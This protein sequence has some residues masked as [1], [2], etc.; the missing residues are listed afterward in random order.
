MK[1]IAAL[2]LAFISFGFIYALPVGNPTEASLFLNG[3]WCESTACDPCDPCFSWCDAWSFRIGFYG[4]YVF[5]R[6]LEVKHHNE[7]NDAGDDIQTTTLFTNAGYLVLNFCDRLDIFATLG[8]TH[9]H[10]RTDDLSWDPISLLIPQ[11]QS[12]LDFVS[13]FSWSIGARATLL[14]CGCFGVGIEGQYFGFNPKL[15]YFLDYD[16]GNF[17]YLDEAKR[18]HYREW[19]VGLGAAYRFAT[20]CPTIALIPYMAVKWA[21]CH[22][23]M[24]DFVFV[25]ELDDTVYTL[26]DLRSK[27]L[28]GYALGLT[29]TLCDMAGVTVEGRWGDEKALYVNGQFRF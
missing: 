20:S 23:D 6:H 26:N 22:L 3:A 12:E 28:W 21:G 13:N 18:T 19:Q 16:D 14:Q 7:D 5:N 11:S 2:V 10:I 17:T 27:K 15:N 24:N 25:D 9:L 8:S 1:K 29:F 4:D